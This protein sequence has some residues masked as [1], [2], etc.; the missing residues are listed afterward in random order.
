MAP[1]EG[2]FSNRD[3]TVIWQEALCTHS[4]R[5]FRELPAV[6]DPP[7]DAF[8]DLEAAP[9]P[10]IMAQVDRCPSGALTYVKIGT[11]ETPAPAG[12][13]PLR[14][15]VLKNGPVVV[16]GAIVIADSSGLV[17][18][19]SGTTALC[20][21]GQSANKPFCDGAHSRTGFQAD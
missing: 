15:E 17:T 12:A 11:A 2:R 18:F 3:I 21:C 6:F 8:M 14:V 9:S 19:R 7:G 1:K 13:G 4:G 5:C 16:K 20:R 10:V